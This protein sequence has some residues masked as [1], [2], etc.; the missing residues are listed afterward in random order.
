VIEILT[1][2]TGNICRSPLA[3]ML[4][5]TRL[6]AFAPLVKSAGTRGLSS[7]PMTPEALELAVAAGVP[8]ADAASHRSRYLVETYLSSPDLILAMTREHRREVVEIAPSRLRDTYA[9]RE[10]ARLSADISD[11]ELAQ[12]A[13]KAGTD[14]A[15]RVRGVSAAVAA[16]RGVAPLPADPA[17]DDVI[18]PYRRSWETYQRAA[19]QLEPAVDAVVRVLSIALRGAAGSPLAGTAAEATPDAASLD[20]SRQRREHA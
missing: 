15:A 16:Q 5:R 7:A 4:L 14:A 19:A 10:F 18:D 17:D 3:E 8:E 9:I 11:D 20:L 2:C 6:S 12:A 13:E 1:V